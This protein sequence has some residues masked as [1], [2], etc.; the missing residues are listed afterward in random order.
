[1]KIIDSHG[2]VS[3]CPAEEEL[4]VLRHSAA[5]IMAQAIKRLFPEADFA[6]GPATEKGFYDDVDLGD[7][8]LSDDDLRAIE[9]EMHKITKENLPFKAFILPREEAIKLMEERREKYKVEHIGDLLFG[10]MSVTC[11]RHLDFHRRILIDRQ[12]STERGGYRHP[13]CVHYLNHRLRILI[14]E[15]CLDRQ[16]IGVLAV[17]KFLQEEELFLQSRILTVRLMHI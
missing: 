13:L 8:K 14:H 1:M 4:H 17:N 5:H 3:E 10:G 12:V 16:H 9:E 2:V 7:R 6:F 11:N 15:L